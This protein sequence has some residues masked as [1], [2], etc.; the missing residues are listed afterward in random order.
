M[1]TIIRP[2]LDKKPYRLRCRFKIGPYPGRERIDRERVRVAERF[3]V[4]MK[5]QGW[6]YDARFGFEIKGPYVPV[7]PQPIRIP[8]TPTAREMAYAVSQGARFLDN[9]LTPGVSNLPVLGESEYWEYE[10]SSVFVR[11]QILTEQ[12]DAHEVAL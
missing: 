5:K 10:L 7:T 9:C 3:I 2:T 6:E 1:Q 11:T 4:D 12:P 8:R